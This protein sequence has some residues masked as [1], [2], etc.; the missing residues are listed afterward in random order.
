MR[1]YYA[2][3][4]GLIFS[5]NV[6]SFTYHLLEIQSLRVELSLLLS[7]QVATNYVALLITV[8]LQLSVCN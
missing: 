4:S 3:D 6:A 2:A 8:A 5:S 7:W 1:N